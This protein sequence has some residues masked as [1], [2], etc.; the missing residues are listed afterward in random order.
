M[1]SLDDEMWTDMPCAALGRNLRVSEFSAPVSYVFA[2]GHTPGGG[3]SPSMCPQ[4]G[5]QSADSD[6]IEVER[7]WDMN[8][9]FEIWGLLLWYDW[10]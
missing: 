7:K 6:K 5:S 4:H 1:T 8:Q 10:I 2:T 9:V 3:C